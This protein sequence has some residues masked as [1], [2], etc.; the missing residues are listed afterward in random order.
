MI[1]CHLTLR[2]HNKLLQYFLI[3]LLSLAISSFIY[4]NLRQNQSVCEKPQVLD[5][6]PAE[7]I[8]LDLCLS[9]GSSDQSI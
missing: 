1:K 6:V 8:Y 7:D 9:V 3:C 2:Y 4:A 5:H